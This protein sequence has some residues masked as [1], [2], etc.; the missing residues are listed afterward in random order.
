[1]QIDDW[2]LFRLVTVNNSFETMKT[3]HTMQSMRKEIVD[4]WKAYELEMKRSTH[5]E[6][7]AMLEL[8]ARFAPPDFPC[9][10]DYHYI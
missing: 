8:T 3:K 2:S 1:M 5:L 9:K 6:T 7:N 4:E 10:K